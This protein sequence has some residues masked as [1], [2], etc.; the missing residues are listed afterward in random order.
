[1]KQA[2][3]LFCA[4]VLLAGCA[5]PHQRAHVTLGKTAARSSEV[6]AV[7]DRYRQVRNTAISLLD[8]KP[9]SIV[10]SGSVLAID[11]GS[12]EVSQR[13]AEKQKQD[14]SRVE[15]DSILTPRFAKYPLWFVAE[16]H[17]AARDVNRI[18]VF[19][20]DAAA[21][22]WLLVATPETVSTTSL[23]GLRRI[24]SAVVMVRPTDGVGM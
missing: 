12:F 20:R 21:D 8:P 17:G 18:Q 14:T 15:L 24:G 10:E 19:Q 9:L 22:P 6:T 2:A 11:S 5:T 23:P 4:V 16:T 1:M 3:L 7:L 13:L